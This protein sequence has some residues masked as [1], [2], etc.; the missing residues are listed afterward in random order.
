[1]RHSVPDTF[2]LFRAVESHDDRKMSSREAV[3]QFVLAAKRRRH[4]AWGFQPQETS[5]AEGI[6][7]C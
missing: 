4:T 2:V 6:Q 5:Q 1:M 3:I 7:L